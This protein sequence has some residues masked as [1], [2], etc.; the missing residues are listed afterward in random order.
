M[1][2]IFSLTL[3]RLA[4]LSIPRYYIRSLGQLT[5]TIRTLAC[6]SAYYSQISTLSHHYRAHWY[7][8][9]G[10]SCFH[11]LSGARNIACMTHIRAR[12]PE[13][14]PRLPAKGQ[15]CIQPREES[16]K[17]FLHPER[18]HQSVADILLIVAVL[19]SDLTC[20]ALHELD[21]GLNPGS[22]F[23]AAWNADIARFAR[24]TSANPAV[25]D[26]LQ[27]LETGENV[28]LEDVP[29]VR[30]STG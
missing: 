28:V 15:P 16:P 2:A 5:I 18:T 27:I 11:A 20:N 4:S 12:F 26:K 14:A 1:S 19:A 17:A 10:L 25:W 22:T 24:C 30:C 7:S 8:R 9:V 21:E 13:A 23:E 3:L 29:L 6:E